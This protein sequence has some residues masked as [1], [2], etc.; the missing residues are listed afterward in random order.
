MLVTEADRVEIVRIGLLRAPNEAC[1]LLVTAPGLL[2]RVEEVP[3]RSTEP[4]DSCQM[5]DP[6]VRFAMRA[7]LG[8]LQETEVDLAK[9]LVVWHTHPGGK[10]GPGRMDMEFK[11][12]LRGIRCLVVALPGGEAVQF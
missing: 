12:Q 10:I 3:N 6:D 2:K 11:R 4:R 9:H 8:D 5:L 7:I 1:G